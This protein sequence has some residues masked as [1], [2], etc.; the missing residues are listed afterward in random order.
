MRNQIEQRGGSLIQ[1]TALSVHSEREHVIKLVPSTAQTLIKDVDLFDEQF[2]QDCVDQNKLMDL[3]D[4]RTGQRPM[5]DTYDANSIMNG[6]FG[7]KDLNRREVGEKVSD[8]DDDEDLEE[9]RPVKKKPVKAYPKMLYCKNEQQEILDWIV[10]KEAFK[11][12]RCV[13]CHSESF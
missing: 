7:W 8:I 5:F 2:I 9:A 6:F 12:L 13:L 4:Y 1:K 11:S 10:K 3:N